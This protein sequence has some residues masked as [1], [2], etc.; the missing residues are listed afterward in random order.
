MKQPVI[1]VPEIGLLRT[2][3]VRFY[4]EPVDCQFREVGGEMTM[5]LLI[6]AG[7]LSVC[8]LVTWLILRRPVRQIVEDVRVETPA[9][10]STSG[11]NGWKPDLFRP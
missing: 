7:I 8:I 4:N 1:A 5:A 11:A 2:A 6:G 10:F 3:P 9:F